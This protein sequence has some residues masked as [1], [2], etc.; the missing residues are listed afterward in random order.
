[1]ASVKDGTPAMPLDD[2]GTHIGERCGLLAVSGSESSSPLANPAF[3]GLKIGEALVSCRI[4]RVLTFHKRSYVMSPLAEALGTRD[5]VLKAL[6]ANKIDV[7]DAG[8]RLAQLGGNSN[9]KSSESVSVM[10][11][12]GRVR[13][14]NGARADLTAAQAVSVLK[15]AE[16][17]KEV[18]KRYVK[19]KVT[20][21]HVESKRK[22]GDDYT[23]YRLGALLVGY[24]QSQVDEVLAFVASK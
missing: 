3:A 19:E 10:E 11:K 18:L 21:K 20:T 4:E 1:M 7:S 16:K 5:E 8:A 23:E 24:K 17:I 2:D 22:G 6:A 13:V 14:Q 15:Q 9:G 12:S